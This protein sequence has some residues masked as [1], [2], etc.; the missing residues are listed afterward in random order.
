MNSKCLFAAVSAMLV[1]NGGSVC[2]DDRV[3]APQAPAPASSM[4]KKASRAENRRLEKSVTHSLSGTRGLDATNI[5]V[6]ARG[7]RVTLAGSVPEASQAGL[8][9][10]VAKGVAGVI[11]VNDLLT[12]RPEGL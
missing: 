8:A 11:A 5:V 4:S 7:G 2:A 12:V 10:S 6:V 1:W 3:N 9:V